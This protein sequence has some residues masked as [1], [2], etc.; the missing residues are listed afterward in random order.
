MP[1]TPIDVPAL[2]EKTAFLPPAF[3]LVP[4]LLVLLDDP[5]ASSEDLAE[6]IRIDPGL[7]VDLLHIANSAYLAGRR[8]SESLT[9]AILTVGV[10]EIYRVVLSII[11]RAGLK[12]SDP[13]LAM[14]VDLWRHSLAVAVAGQLL[15]D[16]LPGER[17][18]TC[19]TAGL[20]HDIG[21][22][23]L[24]SAAP[25]LY[26]TLLKNCE[27]SG[28]PLFLAERNAF[29]SD[30]MQVADYLLKRWNFPERLVAAIGAHHDAS[31]VTGDAAPLAALLYAAN[32]LAYRVGEGNGFPVY[33]VNPDPAALALVSLQPEDLPALEEP[34]TIALA[35]ERARF[36]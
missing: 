23:L 21:K 19:F 15:A 20:L 31:S 14:R 12:A 2:V 32:I 29:N 30:H 24:A 13:F 11:A 28:E 5:D 16:R 27:V 17:I 7:T 10:G 34:F 25:E 26:G 22:V 1:V 4:R 6:V 35:R 8:P 36:A 9:E 18:E 33:M 3:E